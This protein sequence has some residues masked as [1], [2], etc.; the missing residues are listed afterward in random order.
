MA[1]LA[2]D[3]FIHYEKRSGERH[4]VQVDR[5]IQKQSGNHIIEATVK[6][7]SD[8]QV[9]I[10]AAIELDVGML[11]NFV[12]TDILDRRHGEM[13]LQQKLNDQQ[14]Q[15][16]YSAPEVMATIQNNTGLVQPSP[17]T[18]TEP[19]MIQHPLFISDVGKNTKI[20]QYGLYDQNIKNM[21]IMAEEQP[22]TIFDQFNQAVE[23]FGQQL[24]PLSH[25]IASSMISLKITDIISKEKHT[26]EVATLYE[27]KY[28]NNGAMCM[29]LGEDQWYVYST[30]IDELKRN[31]ITIINDQVLIYYIIEPA[32]YN[33]SLIAEITAGLPQRYTENPLP[34][35]QWT[36]VTLKKH[37]SNIH[38]AGVSEEWLAYI[39]ASYLSGVKF[40]WDGIKPKKFPED[41]RESLKIMARSLDDHELIAIV[42]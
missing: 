32:P 40:N 16:I 11:N 5:L 23:E 36:W 1:T 2:V 31:T 4:L 26:F 7:C 8:D 37:H 34:P 20:F 42:G 14:Q 41:M 25:N 18:Q 35:K 6:W 24:V 29:Y 27:F 38:A 15:H 30:T 21:I 13:V 9:R 28:E 33:G 39:T 17:E 10:P 3:N 19:E 22:S 12:H